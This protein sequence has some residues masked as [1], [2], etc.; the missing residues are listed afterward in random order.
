MKNNVY[1]ESLVFLRKL[2]L[3]T[4]IEDVINESVKIA[5]RLLDAE[6]AT[7]FI[8]DYEKEILYSRVGTGLTNQTIELKLDEGVAGWVATN[9]KIV[10]IKDV[11]KDSRFSKVTDS[12][13]RFKTKNMLCAPLISIK[14]DILGVL[15]VLNKKRGYFLKRDE[16]IIEVLAETIAS[17][18]EN[19]NLV[20]E[21]ELMLKST[22]KALSSAIDARD[23]AT[24]GHSERVSKLAVKIGQQLGYPQERLELL[25]YAALLHDT[26]K[27]GIRDNILLK[28]GILTPEEF[29]I[30]KKHAEFTYSILEQIHYPRHLKN[31]P[32]IASAHHE[33]LDGSGY[34]KGLTKE[35]IPEEVRIIT[36]CDVFDALVAHDRPYKKAMAVEQARA[37]LEEGKETLFDPKIVDLLFEK[38]LY[39]EVFATLLKKTGQS[40][41]PQL[42]HNLNT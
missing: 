11:Y 32:F 19:F 34:P 9:K 22:I 39:E 31:I 42:I 27:L 37:I 12:K 40:P 25:E 26:G 38:K 10:N 14:G 4:K 18:L 28:S 21:N 20:K 30:M 24:K 41:L 8:Y 23:P 33:K 29:S 15:Q 16:Q 36:V 2:L 3:Y 13:L 35:Q 7:L 17:I 6:R 1:K 5:T